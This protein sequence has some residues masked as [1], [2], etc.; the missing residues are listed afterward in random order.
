[1]LA[2]KDDNKLIKVVYRQPLQVAKGPESIP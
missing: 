1:L 2:N